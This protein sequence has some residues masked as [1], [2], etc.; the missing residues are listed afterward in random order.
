[1]S[2]QAFFVA[3]VPLSWI[4]GEVSVSTSAARATGTAKKN[5]TANPPA[6]TVILRFTAFLPLVRKSGSRHYPA[7]LVPANRAA[8]LRR[9]YHN[10]YVLVSIPVAVS[11]A[12]QQRAFAEW[13]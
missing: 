4:A 10:Q 13:L 8:R 6:R 2:L 5:A 9:S 3:R 11:A 12:N 1:L 7:A